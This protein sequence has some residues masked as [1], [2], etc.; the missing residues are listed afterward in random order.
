MTRVVAVVVTRNRLPMLQKCIDA[1]RKQTRPCD[2]IIVVDNGSDDGTDLWLKDQN[3]LSALRQTN[4]GGAGGFHTG[5]AAALRDGYESVW[6]M[7]DDVIPSGNCLELLLC[8]L[9]PGVG[10]VAPLVT[11][12]AGSRQLCH[13]KR[14]HRFPYLREFCAM[15]ND[16]L[17][18]ELPNG[19]LVRIEANGFVGLLVS[20]TAIR[21]I[22]LPRKG[23]FI[24]WDDTEFTFRITRTFPGY[25]LVGATVEHHNAVVAS[26]NSNQLP[27]WRFY[28]QWRNRI[29]FSWTVDPFPLPILVALRV[30]VG[31]GTR[32][33]IDGRRPLRT[34]F[35]ALWYA[36]RDGVSRTDGQVDLATRKP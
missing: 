3:D 30:A 10:F 18:R 33:I 7:D 5:I 36:V 15:S 17:D 22:G 29:L 20:C 6:L 16:L 8:N 32:T 24:T 26:S 9:H 12:P 2:H 23:F 4:T 25:V 14:F 13:H 35:R 21:A 1:I 31:A 34:Y 11:T 27:P 28:Y 19:G